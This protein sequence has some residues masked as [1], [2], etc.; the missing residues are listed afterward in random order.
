MKIGRINELNDPFEFLGVATK[1]ASLR[2]RYQRLKDG[3]ND[4]MGLV[5]FSANWD[6]PVQWAHYAD[7]H[8]G[9][10]LGFEVR[11]QAHK[12]TYVSERL[13]A[14]PSAMKS[15]GP[16]AE[17]HVTEILTTKFEHWSY[18]DEYRLFPQLQE[19]DPSGRYFLA[20][21][22]QVALREVIV[23]HRSA[24]SRADIAQ[25]LGPLAPQ[26][27][28]YK[29]RLAFRSFDVVRQKNDRLWE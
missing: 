1:S 13:L 17:A 16:K 4:Y 8:R 26:V 21:D 25:A 23:G 22:D 15:E 28:A 3:L 10:C 12:V 7:R 14:R 11:A 5:C 29:A 2:R 24:I 18:E 20:F 9:I 19:R 27:I 6:N